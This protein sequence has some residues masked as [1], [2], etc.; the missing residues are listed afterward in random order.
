MKDFMDKKEILDLKRQGKSNRAVA[1]ELGVNRKTVANY[2]REYQRKMAE[3]S[4]T[5]ADTRKLQ[6]ELYR[7]PKYNSAG[8]KA[9]KYTEEMDARL[10]E[11][12][13]GERRKDGILGAGHKQKLTNKQI[14][15]KLIDEGYD[16]SLATINAKLAKIR[17]KKKEVFIR[18]EYDF[19]DR[20]EYDFGEVRLDCGEEVKTYHMAVL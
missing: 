9:R 6:D 2:W 20:L 11:I 14:H 13:A 4:K 8:R 5:G 12:L 3:L 15:Q 19:G 10:R 18:R 17:D 1:R 7:K 16:I